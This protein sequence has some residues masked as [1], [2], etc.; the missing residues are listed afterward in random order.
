MSALDHV[1]YSGE[2]G[3]IESEVHSPLIWSPPSGAT[4]A[5]STPEHSSRRR[6]L[7]PPRWQKALRSAAFAFALPIADIYDPSRAYSHERYLM[8]VVGSEPGD[9]GMFEPDA[10]WTFSHD[11]PTLWLTTPVPI[12]PA[13]HTFIPSLGL[14]DEDE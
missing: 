6:I 14:D 7:M 10:V 12:L 9:F 4:M 5:V 8:V 3:A 13:R 11:R 1:A 2:S